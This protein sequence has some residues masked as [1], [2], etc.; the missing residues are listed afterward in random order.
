MTSIDICNIALSYLGEDKINALDEDGTNPESLC[1]Q[2]FDFCLENLLRRHDW[3]FASQRV[4]LA[5]ASSTPLFGWLYEYPFPV[6]CLL[7]REVYLDADYEVEQRNILTDQN[8]D[9]QIRYTKKVTD[10]TELDS[11]FIKALAHY[12]A[13]EIGLALTGKPHWVQAQMQLYAIAYEEA[14]NQDGI[15]T[16]PD[17]TAIQWVDVGHG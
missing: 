6:N 9:V 17:E 7:V 13:S 3:S 2:F 8:G 14:E 1:F 12:L 4:E 11:N 5:Q 10:M 15:E 16:F